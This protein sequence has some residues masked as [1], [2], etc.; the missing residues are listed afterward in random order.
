MHLIPRP[1]ESAWGAGR[2]AVAEP[3]VRID[4]TAGPAGSTHPERYTLLVEDSGVTILAA[5]GVGVSHA[6]R[7]LDQLR[8]ADGTAPCG[9]VRDEPRYDWR[10]L[11]LDIARH[12]FGVEVLRAVIDLL[13]R[14]K[15]NVLHLHLT[16][17]QG[18]R[19]ETPTR[20]EFA[21]VSGPTASGGDVGG[22]LTVADFEGIVA[23]AAE[24][25]IEVIPEIDVPGHVNAATHAC[26]DLMPDGRP[27]PAYGGLEVGFSR[28]TYDLPATRPFLRDVFGDLAGVTPGQFLHIGGDEAHQL[29]T[30]EYVR[31]VEA[32][33]AEVTE[34]GKRV[35]CW[36]EGAQAPLPAGSVVQWWDPRIDPAPVLRAAADGAR[37]VISP[38]DRIYLDMK[39]TTDYP[40][41]QDWAALIEVRDSYE[42]EPLEVLEGLSPESIVGVEAA[43]W[44]ENIATAD[45]LFAMLLPRL[46]AVA[47]VA[48]TAPAGR[49]WVD[50]R[51]R[52]AAEAGH[53]RAAG[54]A[55]HPSPQIDWVG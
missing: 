55:F 13:A 12:F 21:Q 30:D 18:W 33:C 51:R 40:D 28:L 4:P 10:G 45:A 42:W 27:T 3:V 37:V 1:C 43:I 29:G 36:Q 14:Y 47:E 9:V 5:S 44:T 2:V 54:L 16:D 17:D 38:S 41:G 25:F 49:D 24:R 7:T 11:S 39:Y 26:G 48:W 20:P 23:Y 32:A 31:L 52:V 19:I 53:W 34:A 15:F 8:D 22:Y 50:F 6:R 35:V 46:T